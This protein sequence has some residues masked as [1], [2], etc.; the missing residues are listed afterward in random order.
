M[1]G[2]NPTPEDLR[3]QEIYRDWVHSNP[4]T[5]LDGGVRDDLTWQVWWRDLAVMP[6][7]HYDAPSGR[8]RRKFVRMLGEEL[9]GV[10]DRRWNLER[11]I[12]FQTVILQQAFHVTAS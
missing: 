11:F 2:Y 1:P 3:L 10:R 8:V 4:D 12:L 7:R 9:K 5:H 6:L